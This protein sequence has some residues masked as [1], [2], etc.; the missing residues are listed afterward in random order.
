[1][2]CM[3]LAMFLLVGFYAFGAEP[4]AADSAFKKIDV[5]TG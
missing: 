3:A 5:A 4:K 2:R 1:M